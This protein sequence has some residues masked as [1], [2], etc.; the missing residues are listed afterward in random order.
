MT[1][2]TSGRIVLGLCVAQ[3]STMFLALPAMAE[4]GEKWKITASMSMSGMTMPGQTSVVCAAKGI[5]QAPTSEQ[6]KNCTISNVRHSGTKDLMHMRCVMDGKPMDAEMESERLGPDHFRTVM[7]MKTGQGN[8]DMISESQ[9]IP[10]ACDT[11]DNVKAA[12]Q[13]ARDRMKSL[14]GH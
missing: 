8:M 14:T 2:S 10:G 1:Y 4:P 9:K 6:Q 3:L 5:T 13:Q 12:Q 7:H 11:A